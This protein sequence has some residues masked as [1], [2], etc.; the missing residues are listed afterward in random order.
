MSLLVLQ[1]ALSSIHL[2]HVGIDAIKVDMIAIILL[3]FQLL[4][5]DIV[6]FSRALLLHLRLLLPLGLIV[7]SL[8]L[9]SALL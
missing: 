7:V 3:P 8:L 1:T 6:S 9:G 4:N 5:V 2:V